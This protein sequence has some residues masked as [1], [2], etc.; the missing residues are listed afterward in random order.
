MSD[1]TYRGSFF[2]K[3]IIQTTAFRTTISQLWVRFL[4][5][6]CITV[7]LQYC[8]TTK[9]GIRAR[10]VGLMVSIHRNLNATYRDASNN[11]KFYWLNPSVL[12]YRESLLASQDPANIQ[13]KTDKE[14]QYFELGGNIP[15]GKD[16]NWILHAD[17]KNYLE[18]EGNIQSGT[19]K[20]DRIWRTKKPFWI[21]LKGGFF[22]FCQYF[23]QHCFICCPSDSTVSEDAGIEPRAITTSTLAVVARL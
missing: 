12:T 20:K 1:R 9:E 22:G 5:T 7:Y 18:L 14:V 3:H 10:Y 13:S 11:F 23:I 16:R 19:D 15:L 17:L 8:I 21:I 6:K 2:S 4:R